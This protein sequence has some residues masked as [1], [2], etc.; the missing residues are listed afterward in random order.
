VIWPA[1]VTEPTARMLPPSTATSSELSGCLIQDPKISGVLFPSHR[2][3]IALLSTASSLGKRLM[4]LPEWPFE[5]L[6]ASASTGGGRHKRRSAERSLVCRDFK[7]EF[8][9]HEFEDYFERWR[10]AFADAGFH[11]R[12][13]S[14]VARSYVAKSFTALATT[15]APVIVASNCEASSDER[16]FFTSFS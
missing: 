8:T 14:R 3:R 5:F 16:P 11:N 2:A 10:P 12:V 15:N 13:N 7:T 1:S 6:V 4:R 9:R